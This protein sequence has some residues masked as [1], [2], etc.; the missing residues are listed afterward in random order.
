MSKTLA[1][2]MMFMCL[3]LGIIVGIGIKTL[4]TTEQGTETIPYEKLPRR[5]FIITIERRQQEEL[6][7][8]LKKFA[9]KGGFAIRIAPITPS[10]EDFSI[11]MWR[12][13]I[14]IFGA[15]PFNPGEFRIGFYD[16]DGAYP[17][18]A[19]EW[20]L[21]DLENDLKSFIGEISNA[22]FSLEK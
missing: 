14:K 19:P 3:L 21:D 15:N 11:E 2:M 12:E 9:D 8:Q 6:F 1:F 20:A 17:Y 10:G 5:K 18:P 7:S 16:T 13:D 4:T 22:T